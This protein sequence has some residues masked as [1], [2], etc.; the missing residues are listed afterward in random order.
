MTDKTFERTW[1]QWHL[2]LCTT[3]DLAV[4]VFD[5]LSEMDAPDWLI[6]AAAICRDRLIAQSYSAPV[7]PWRELPQPLDQ[8]D[9][10][11]G[12]DA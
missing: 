2:D 1:N 7:P 4:H 10:H 11:V 12:P 3:V 5:Q 8:A 9:K 6:S